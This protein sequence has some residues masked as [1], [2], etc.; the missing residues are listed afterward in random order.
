LSL[1]LTGIINQIQGGD[2]KRYEF[3][4]WLSDEANQANH[5]KRDA[6]VMVVLGNPPYSGESANKGEWISNI[7]D[8]YKKEPS[9]GRLQE[10]NPKW[11]NDDY[12][13]FIR[14]GQYLIEKNS[15]GILAFINPHGYLD[16]PT[17]RG[18][19]WH[20]LNTF[21][22]I[23]TLDLHGNSKKKE[24]APDG[25][26]DENVFDIQQG[27]SIN[28][29]IKTGKK[30]KDEL[31][32]VMQFD[33]YGAREY[34]YQFLSKNT[35]R[36][37]SFINLNLSAPQYLFI[38]K[39]FN[40]KKEY[41]LGFEINQIFS[42]NSVG[43]VTAR[44]GFTIQENK[45]KVIQ[46]I[47]EFLKLE[48]EQ[49]RSK[50]NLG[51]DA[52]DWKVELA[53]TDLKRTGP[54][55]NRIVRI[56]YRPFDE[57]FTYYTG[58]SKGFHCMPRGEVMKHMIIGN[59]LGLVFRRQQPESKDLY[60]FCSYNIIADG[61]IRSDNKGSESFA[62][63]YIFPTT[64]GQQS[65]E[66]SIHRRPNLNKE[67][68]QKIAECI[69]LTFTPEKE[70]KEDTFAPIDIFDYIYAILHSPTYRERYKEFL[71]IDFPRVPYPKDANT[72]WQLAKLGVQLRE[73]HLLES[74]LTEGY[75][76]GYPVNGNN[77]VGKVRYEVG[78][79]YIN[80]TQY[81]EGVPEVAW[82]FYIGGY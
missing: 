42:V 33:L 44:D 13:K 37:I 30:Q 71:K 40:V 64:N 24:M 12:V 14:F 31:A 7:M 51:K 11:L 54:D 77:V 34:K 81:F 55:Y 17:F 57:R 58:K 69:G 26:K 66:T 43:I 61:Y 23:Y 16:N 32:K 73:S 49:A 60:L 48:S 38:Q 47:E 4:S 50:F 74:P 67:I 53:K 9:G 6:P 22:K 35:L 39:D 5:I 62:P 56:S 45:Q 63:L 15:E 72:F 68:V 25:S 21:D 70:N 82:N 41:D 46:V 20:L 18:M 78:K 75:I 10:K 36:T 52:R 29:F 79:V 1:V 59:N 8:D 76:T 65:L 2:I 19:R 80:T 28:I 27:V 3:A